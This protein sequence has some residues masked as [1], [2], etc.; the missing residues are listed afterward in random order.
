MFLVHFHFNLF[1]GTLNLL[2]DRNVYTVQDL[3][4][5]VVGTH[6][7]L[8]E[9]DNVLAVV[10]HRD[11]TLEYRLAELERN[12]YYLSEL[13]GLRVRLTDTPLHLVDDR[14]Q[15]FILHNVQT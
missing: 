4:S 13:G 3:V 8:R 6:D 14:L 15:I 2:L 1:D 9:L 11:V 12:P 10:I 5:P 7:Y